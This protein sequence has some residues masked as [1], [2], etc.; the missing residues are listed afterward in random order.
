VLD[1]PLL[2]QIFVAIFAVSTL[3]QQAGIQSFMQPISDSLVQFTTTIAQLAP[4]FVPA[5]I[6]VGISLLL[7]RVLAE[8]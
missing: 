6:L 8:L 2:S 4:K 3:L 5:L 1:F 7:G